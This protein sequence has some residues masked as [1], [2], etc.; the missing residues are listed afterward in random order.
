MRGPI[1]NVTPGVF[2]IELAL[3]LIRVGDRVRVS[4]NG[5]SWKTTVIRIDD[6][7]NYWCATRWQS[8]FGDS[9][10]HEPCDVRKL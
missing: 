8:I 4:K 3:D 5:K 10:Y 9:T 1:V 7:G 6:F 2:Y